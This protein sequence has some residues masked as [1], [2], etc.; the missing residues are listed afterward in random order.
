MKLPPLTFE[1]SKN[2]F[3]NTMVVVLFDS[4]PVEQSPYQGLH[5]VGMRGRNFCYAIHQNST[6]QFSGRIPRQTANSNFNE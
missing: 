2:S 4:D 3:R 6:D 1:E 5:G